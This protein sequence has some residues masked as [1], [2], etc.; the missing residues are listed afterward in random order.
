MIDA[1]RLRC[2][3]GSDAPSDAGDSGVPDTG[4]GDYPV[5]PSEPPPDDL[6]VECTRLKKE[7]ELEKM[8]AELVKV[9]AENTAGAA[10][11]ATVPRVSTQDRGKYMSRVSVLVHV[12][13]M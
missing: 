2:R 4:G 1:R 10:A 12:V 13:R 8:K 9:K 6:D 11:G 5:V 3:R 7:L